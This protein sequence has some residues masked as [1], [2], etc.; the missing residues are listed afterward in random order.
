LV[1][2]AARGPERHPLTALAVTTFGPLYASALLA[3][4]VAIR[5]GPHADAHPRGS[6]ALAVMPLAITWVCDACAM[7]A[8]T[9]IGGPR[10]APVLAPRE[11]WAGAVGGVIGGLNGAPAYGR[12]AV[13]RGRRTVRGAGAPGPGA[14]AGAVPGRGVDGV[15]QRRPAAAANGGMEAGVCRDRE[16]RDAG[17]GMRDANW[18]RMPGGGRDSAGRRHRGE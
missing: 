18:S 15:L 13:R 3:F 14:R 17:C 12:L 9:L 10:L 7:A 8:G 5:H 4:L 1:V 2:A 6:V 11:T 16:W